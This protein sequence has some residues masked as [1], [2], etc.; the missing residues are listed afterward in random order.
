MPTS[1]IPAL[2]TWAA[3]RY[4]HAS[5]PR[6]R[7]IAMKLDEVAWA[8]AL[9]PS[10]P[11]VLAAKRNRNAMDAAGSRIDPATNLGAAS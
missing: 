9:R 1:P 6:D 8:A 5:E 3:L 4:Q 2:L 7:N 10:N 11:A